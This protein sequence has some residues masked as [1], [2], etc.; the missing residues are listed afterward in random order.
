MGQAKEG[1]VKN[2]LESE[3]QSVQNCWS[4]G[5]KKVIFEGYNKELTDPIKRVKLKFEVFNWIC[6]LRFEMNGL[7]SLFKSC[8]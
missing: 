2:A 4:K 8:F 3:F 1:C 6:K 5:Y 7:K